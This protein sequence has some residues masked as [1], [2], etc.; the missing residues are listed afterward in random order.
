MKNQIITFLAAAGWTDNPHLGDRSET[1]MLSPDEQWEVIAWEDGR[2]SLSER[3]AA[4]PDEWNYIAGSPIHAFEAY[5]LN[6]GVVDPERAVVAEHIAL[7]YE[8][9]LI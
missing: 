3:D 6:H 1:W 8:D 4:N 5:M 9:L 7:G 2:W